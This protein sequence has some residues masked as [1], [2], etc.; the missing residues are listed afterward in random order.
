MLPPHAGAGYSNA[1]DDG[2]G[3]TATAVPPRANLDWMRDPAPTDLTPFQTFFR[4]VEWGNSSVGPMG[5]W[6]REL[7]RM[8]FLE[9]ISST[10][11][12]L[13][14]GSIMPHEYG[15]VAIA[16]AEGA[17]RGNHSHKTVVEEHR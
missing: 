9:V 1:A 12:M 3:V 10:C 14:S 7:K 4:K 2:H 15:S 13:I 6:P 11:S 17:Q 5:N 16:P 8:Y